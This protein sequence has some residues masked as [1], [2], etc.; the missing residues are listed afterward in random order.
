MVSFIKIK[1]RLCVRIFLSF[2]VKVSISP[3]KVQAWDVST[4]KL[5]MKLSYEKA[6]H[7]MLVKLTKGD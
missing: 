3:K 6:A 4:K 2:K 1:S 5:H 7:K